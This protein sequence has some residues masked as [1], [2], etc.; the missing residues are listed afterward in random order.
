MALQSSWERSVM[1]NCSWIFLLH[2]NRVLSFLL[3]YLLQSSSYCR[4]REHGKPVQRLLWARLSKH[5]TC[6]SSHICGRLPVNSRRK[7]V[8][9]LT[10]RRHTDCKLVPN[11]HH[12]V[13]DDNDDDD[14]N[15]NEANRICSYIG[16][17]SSSSICVNNSARWSTAN[18]TINDQVSKLQQG[19]SGISYHCLWRVCRH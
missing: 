3:L 17:V 13:V 18:P 5:M 6:K 9:G 1:L 14:D 16:I 19:K 11:R 10:R 7:C 4:R 12:L 15:V 8:I 2:L